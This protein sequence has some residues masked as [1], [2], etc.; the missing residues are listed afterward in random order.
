M[1]FSWLA[2]AKA[3]ASFRAILYCWAIFSAVNPILR[4]TSGWHSTKYGLGARRHPGI[5]TRLMDSD[6]PA[7]ITSAKPAMMR[8][9]AIAI[10]WSPEEQKRL[11]VIPGTDCGG[12]ARRLTMRAMLCPC[13]PREMRTRGSRLQSLRERVP[14]FGARG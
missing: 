12:P 3:S 8:S 10:A 2:N 13:S 1:A 7:M 9:D 6:P 4:Y 14:V 5:G 11:I